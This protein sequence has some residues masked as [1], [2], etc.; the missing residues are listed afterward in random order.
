MYVCVGMGMRV[1]TGDHG[2]GGVRTPAAG[3]WGSCG[4]PDVG[5]GNST[6]VLYES[7]VCC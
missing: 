4:S 1:S 6:L 3:V 2:A 5:A 7:S